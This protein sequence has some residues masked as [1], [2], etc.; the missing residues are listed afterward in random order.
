MY[1][2]S[3]YICRI[4]H[5]IGDRQMLIS[6]YRYSTNLGSDRYTASTGSELQ[7]CMYIPGHKFARRPRRPR[8]AAGR[9]GEF[10]VNRARYAYQ[11]V[12]GGERGGG[13]KGGGGGE[14]L[15]RLIRYLYMNCQII[16]S[17]GAGWS[18]L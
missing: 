16:Y 11:L 14:Y 4:Y 2:Y 17:A 8:L 7:D 3:S 6:E 13:G 5:A 15:C 9:Y 10:S 18:R 12:S 1:T